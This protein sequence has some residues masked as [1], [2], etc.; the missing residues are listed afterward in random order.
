MFSL[1]LC[2]TTVS[3]ILCLILVYRYSF[4]EA[5]FVVWKHLFLLLLGFLDH[6]SVSFESLFPNTYP[7]YLGLR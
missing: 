3:W 7:I 1:L 6:K 5:A 4:N 2:S